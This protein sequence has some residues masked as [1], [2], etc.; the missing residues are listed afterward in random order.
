ML[1]WY[2][3]NPPDIYFKVGKFPEQYFSVWL[4]S[5]PGDK[6]LAKFYLVVNALLSGQNNCPHKKI[7]R[8][9]FFGP[10]CQ[11]P[12]FF[13]FCYFLSIR[14][15]IGCNSSTKHGTYFRTILGILWALIITTCFMKLWC[16]DWMSCS[17]IVHV[18]ECFCVL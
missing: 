4:F 10:C 1:I 15:W 12:R 18:L 5:N 17:C 14:P 8:T 2:F 13:C 6:M 16:K 11:C 3:S 9:T 7:V